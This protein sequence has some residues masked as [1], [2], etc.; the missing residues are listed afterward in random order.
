[1]TC[2]VPA[3][4]A[5]LTPSMHSDVG[6]E[7]YFAQANATDT[8]VQSHVFSVV[9]CSMPLYSHPRL[10]PLLACL[11]SDSPSPPLHCFASSGTSVISMRTHKAQC[12]GAANG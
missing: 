1:M 2:T 4:P 6:L 7:D 5:R 10:C 11:C 8:G 9:F 3:S 12:H